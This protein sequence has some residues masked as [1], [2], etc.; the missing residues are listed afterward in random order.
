MWVLS[1]LR[2]AVLAIFCVW[3]EQLFAVQDDWNFCWELIF[4]TSCSSSRTLTRKKTK[5]FQVLLLVDLSKLYLD[6]FHWILLNLRRWYNASLK[7][8]CNNK[9][10]R[11]SLPLQDMSRNARILKCHQNTWN[12]AIHEV[13][14]KRQTTLSN[15]KYSLNNSC[16]NFWI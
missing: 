3:R 11:K 15:M 6:T 12:S 2:I 9:I 8:W 16:L 14:W 13:I 5:Y 4:A 10:K 1:V 7:G